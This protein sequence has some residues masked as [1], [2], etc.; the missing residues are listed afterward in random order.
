MKSSFQVLHAGL[1]TTVQDLGRIGF[2]H[3]GVGASGALDPVALRAA[4]ILVG[5]S[6]DTAALE[7]AY[8]GPALR[9]EGGTARCA[10]V[11]GDPEIHVS[12][13]NECQGE[14]QRPG[15]SFRIS[16]GETLT[17]GSVR[18]SAVTYLAVEAGF[19]ISPVL[20]SV[21]TDIRGRMGGCT[22]RALQIGD[23]L[24][25]ARFHCG[26]RDE[27]TFKTLSLPAPKILRVILGPQDDFFSAEEINRFLQTEYTVST[28]SNR[29]GL[30]LFGSVIKSKTSDLISDAT[31][32]GSIQIPGSG[33]PILLLADRQTTGGYPKIATVISADIPSAGR[34][35]TSDLI[36][37]QAVDVNAAVQER[38]KLAAML[39]ALPQ[40]LC[41]VKSHLGRLT[42]WNL[43]S[44]VVDGFHMDELN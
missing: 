32:P 31:A 7:I 21:A 13:S 16:A 28:G 14:R 27:Q 1:L 44:G 34:L 42:E 30:R 26:V 18:N 9:L 2:Q 6:P 37:F 25:L 40:Q 33:Q 5:N 10:V 41:P 11:G 8:R 24:P 35:Q 36:R 22:G 4:N 17:I 23:K 19:N 3:L 20:G 39:E 12:A 43:I 29:M 15:Q 38:R